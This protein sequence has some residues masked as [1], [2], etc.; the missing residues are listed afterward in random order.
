MAQ[1]L[2]SLLKALQALNTAAQ[3]GKLTREQLE[4]EVKQMT[5]GVKEALA[6]LDKEL[7]PEAAGMSA[8]M[9]D[10]FRTQ[11]GVILEAT[12]LTLDESEEMQ[13]LSAE[14]EMIKRGYIR[15]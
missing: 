2:N 7:P 4:T 6:N 5:V 9:V 12:G 11:L 3:Q 10:L 15:S 14:L 8:V 1:D 13:K